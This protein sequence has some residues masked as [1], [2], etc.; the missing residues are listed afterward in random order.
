MEWGKKDVNEDKLEVG[1][2]AYK[3]KLKDIEKFSKALKNDFAMA[4]VIISILWTR[5]SL[6]PSLPDTCRIFLLI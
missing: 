5:R 1:S 6:T 4:T 3:H 2:R